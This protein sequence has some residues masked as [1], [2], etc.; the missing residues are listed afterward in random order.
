M[1][2]R[3]ALA[4]DARPGAVLGGGADGDGPLPLIVA[5]HGL[6]D[7]PENLL[8]MVQRCRL[9]ARV[10]A[11]RGP[12]AY[13]D[14]YS[15]FDVRFDAEGAHIDAAEVT[16][17]SDKLAALIAR[18]AWSHSTVGEPVVTGFSQGGI[19]SFVV[20]AHHPEAVGLAVPIAGMLPDGVPLATDA[21]ARPRVRALHGSDDPVVPLQ[22]A[23]AAVQRLSSAGWDASLTVFAGVPHAVSREEHAELCAALA[24]ALPP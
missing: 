23:Q 10:V 20:A 24:A 17:A 7:R 14:G 16:A 2:G 8:E 21:S 12:L 19:L 22:A 18:S 15:W 13:H 6:G 11:P 1:S 5:V 3:A 9:P 4:A